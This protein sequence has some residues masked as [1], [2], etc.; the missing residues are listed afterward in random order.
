MNTVVITGASGSLGSK[1]R[2]HMEALGGY[3]LRLFTHQ[4]RAGDPAMIQA[5]LC[6]Y[7]PAWVKRFEGADAVLHLAADAAAFSPWPS[8]QRLDI[9]MMLN[10][11]L[12]AVEARVPRLV[13]ASSNWVLGGHRFDDVALNAATPPL[14]INPYGASK[15]FAERAGKSLSERFG[16]SVICLRIGYCQRDVENRPGP[17]M[18]FGRWGQQMWLSDGDWCRA[19]VCAVEAADVP[20]AIVNAVSNNTGMR[21]DLAEAKRLTGYVPQDSHTPVVT[22]LMAAK[23]WFAR[24]RHRKF[25]RWM[26]MCPS[27]PW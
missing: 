24:R 13:F 21:W 10:V 27:Y 1:A 25:I 23:E 26:G 12:A 15:L 18:R 2:R 6:R 3:D 9:D 4:N 14:P 19:A 20:F 11:F 22:P 8:I 7:D 5:D 16:I 17:H